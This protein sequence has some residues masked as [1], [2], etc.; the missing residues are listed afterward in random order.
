MPGAWRGTRASAPRTRWRTDAGPCRS[1][2]GPRGSAGLRPGP[3]DR[4]VAVLAE[5]VTLVPWGAEEPRGAKRAAGVFDAGW[6]LLED[7]HCYRYAGGRITVAPEAPEPGA[8]EHLKGPGFSAGCSTGISAISCVKRPAA[9]GRR[10]CSGDFDGIVFYPKQRLTHE[11][12]QF[13]HQ[14][15]FFK[16]LGPRG[17]DH[18]RAAGAGEDRTPSA[19]AAGLRDR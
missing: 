8:A 18:P 9:S 17:Q 16:A 7:G 10:T 11:A 15:P 14:R 12:R 4:V 5:A 2:P 6:R 13:R 1:D 19:A 3:S